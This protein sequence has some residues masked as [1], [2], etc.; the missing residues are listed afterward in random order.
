MKFT[1]LLAGAAVLACLASPALS[2]EYLDGL[3]QSTDIGGKM[4][5]TDINGM[6]LY[7]FDKDVQGSA[8]NCYDKCAENWPPLI[9]SAEALAGVTATTG[10]TQPTVIT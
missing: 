7:T 2:A 4:V 8:S 3:V 1:S 9:A 6:T 10:R 5:L